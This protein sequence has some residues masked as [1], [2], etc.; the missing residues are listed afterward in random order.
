MI[1]NNKKVNSIV[2]ID[3]AISANCDF[4]KG[5]V[6]SHHVGVKI[7]VIVYCE[8]SKYNLKLFLR[9]FHLCFK[10]IVHIFIYTFR[11]NS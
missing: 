1:Q 11:L 5:H 9:V 10:I 3:E 7:Q 2:I 4:D 8:C 6:I